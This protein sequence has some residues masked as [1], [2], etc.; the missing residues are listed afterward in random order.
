MKLWQYMTIRAIST[1][2]IGIIAISL[3]PQ[4]MILLLVAVLA[5]QYGAFGEGKKL[6]MVLSL[7]ILEQAK[8]IRDE[9]DEK[10]GS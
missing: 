6:G 4:M 7:D 2:F 8:K 3:Q 1:V 5:T 9:I 10:L